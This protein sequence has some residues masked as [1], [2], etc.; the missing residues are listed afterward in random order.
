MN[1]FNIYKTILKDG[2]AESRSEIIEFN[3]YGK[4]AAANSKE[5]M[6]FNKGYTVGTI[7][8]LMGNREVTHFTPNIFKFLSR[9]SGIIRGHEERNL[10]Q[11]NTLVLD[12]D[13]SEVT[14][15]DILIAGLNI[16]M[17]PT[18]I[19]DTDHGYHVYFVLDAPV[20]VS[21]KS[22]FKSLQVAKKISQNIRIAYSKELDGVDLTCNHFGYFRCPNKNNVVYFNEEEQHN[23]KTLMN[24][25]MKK[26]DDEHSE[27]RLII[28]N[29]LNTRNKQI[30]EGWY[31]ALIV[32]SSIYAGHGYGRNNTV[33]TLSLANYQS[34]VT[35]ERCLEKMDEFN[36][37]LEYPLN[38]NDIERIVSSAYSGKYNGA[39]K[40][41]IDALMESWATQSDRTTKGFIRYY[42]HKKARKDRKYSHKSEREADILEFIKENERN[43]VV[44]MTVTALADHFEVSKSTITRVIK[45]SKIIQ[46]KKIGVGRYAET[47]FYTIQSLVQHVQKHKKIQGILKNDFTESLVKNEKKVLGVLEAFERIERDEAYMKRIRTYRD[48][49]EFLL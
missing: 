37:N 46:M 31:R 16:G 18:L 6:I 43:G 28:D 45:Q 9:K 1:L 40:A 36:T 49:L 34:G 32:Q 2:I 26:S 22:G 8:T 25:S 12:I 10:K 11:I 7:E 48:Q 41:Y 4:I 39:N 38:N 47:I 17:M 24:W 33:F 15:Q 20:Y 29:T 5:Q 35:Q 3:N 44:K 30:E 23:F 21:A 19:L 42:K 27:L 13:H 14:P